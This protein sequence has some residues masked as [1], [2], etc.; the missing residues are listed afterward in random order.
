MKKDIKN[1]ISYALKKTRF[2]WCGVVKGWLGV[3]RIFIGYPSKKDLLKEIEH[4]FPGADYNRNIIFEEL[5]SIDNYLAGKSKN[6]IM[7]LDFSESSPFQK[8]VYRTVKQLPYGAI[9]TYS[10]LSTMCGSRSSVRAVAQALAKNPFPLAIPCH[11]VIRSDRSLGGFSAP[12]GVKLKRKLLEM[13]NN[14]EGAFASC[15]TLNSLKP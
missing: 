13:E 2:G 10:E 4:R 1:N 14:G 8:M 11:R 15:Q 3:K 5:R 7:N 6:I 9:T 12:G